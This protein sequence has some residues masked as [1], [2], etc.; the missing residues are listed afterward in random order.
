MNTRLTLLLLAVIGACFVAA[1]SI[2]PEPATSSRIALPDRPVTAEEHP[3]PQPVAAE[4]TVVEAPGTEVV[5]GITVRK[6]RNCTVRRHYV[7][8]GN[9][10]VTDAYSCVP[11]EAPPDDYDQ[12]GNEELRVLAYNDARAASVLGKRLVDVDLEQSRELLLRAVALQPANLDPVLWLAAHAY[13]V[14][15]DST[16]ARDARANTYVLA[17]TAQAMGSAASVDWIIADLERAGFVSGDIAKLDDQVKSTL[18]RIRN[19]QLEV[20]GESVVDEVLL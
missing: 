1:Q 4:E 17:R 3:V 8:L 20:F 5:M 7:D 14:R 15:G 12:Y 9:G 11:N 2:S 18:R 19:I 10:T 6:D 13:S 16:A